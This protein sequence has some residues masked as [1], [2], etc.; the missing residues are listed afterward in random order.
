MYYNTCCVYIIITVQYRWHHH[1]QHTY[2]ILVE[3]VTLFWTCF[4]TCNMCIC[5]TSTLLIITNNFN[6]NKQEAVLIQN[7]KT[8]VPPS[9]GSLQITTMDAELTQRLDIQ[10]IFIT[11]ALQRGVLSLTLF[12]I[13]TSDIPILL[14]SL[15]IYADNITTTVIIHNNIQVAKTCIQSYLHSI[16]A[17]TKSDNLI[18]N[19]YKTTCTL[20]TPE[21]NN[22]TQFSDRLVY[23]RHAQHRKKSSL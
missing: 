7:A 23:T 1:M 22:N 5:F 3:C 19:S 6:C 16:Y 11:D 13:Y 8:Y 12:K 17:W 14:T 9:L 20:F 21:Y 15:V 18:F 10:R 2:S 4:P